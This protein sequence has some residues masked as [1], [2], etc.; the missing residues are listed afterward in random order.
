MWPMLLQGGGTVAK[1]LHKELTLLQC[2]CV[3]ACEFARV[4]VCV[5]GRGVAMH[6][7]NAWGITGAFNLPIMPPG[8][9]RGGR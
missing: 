7:P 6:L 3:Y 5:S 1:H 4:C 2:V 8:M 9:S